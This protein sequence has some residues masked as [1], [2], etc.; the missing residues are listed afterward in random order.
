MV[1]KLLNPW[2][3]DSDGKLVNAETAEKG[4]QCSCPV[5]HELLTLCKKGSGPNARRDHFKHRSDSHCPGPT[6]SD[7]HRLAKEGIHNIIRTAIEKH[8]EIPIFWKCSECGT[9]F[10]ANLIKKAKGIEIEKDLGTSR[11]DIALLDENGNVIVAVEIVYTHEPT[12]DTIKFYNEQN[13]VLVRYVFHSI[14]ECNFLDVKLI[15]PDSVNMCFKHT[16]SNCQSMP[17]PRKLIPLQNEECKYNALAV[18][19]ETPFNDE[20]FL[21]LAFDEQDRVKAQEFIDK[22]SSKFQLNYIEHSGMHY[23]TFVRKPVVTPRP[24][25]RTRY[26]GSP[27]DYIDS[28]MG[29]KQGNKRYGSNRGKSYSSS[30]KRTSGAKKT[31][32]KRRR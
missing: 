4:Q 5:C 1:T 12:D 2:A 7:I 31:G 14:E 17:F 27:I 16:C 19:I 29:Y 24:V 20:P 8:Q 6:E 21:G 18:G 13:I 23:A 25:R 22:R 26:G 3:L 11:P 10:T 30:K 32:G 28:S 9:G 15:F